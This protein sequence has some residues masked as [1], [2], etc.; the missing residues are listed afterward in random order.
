MNPLTDEETDYY[1]AYKEAYEYLMQ[2]GSKG[3][4]IINGCWH[5]T[6]KNRHQSDHTLHGLMEGYFY[7]LGKMLIKE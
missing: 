3:A 1:W 5:R 4:K 6:K 7:A 2:H